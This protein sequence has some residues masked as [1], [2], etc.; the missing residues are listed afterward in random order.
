[1]DAVKNRLYDQL[2]VMP[3]ITPAS[4]S[5]I[6]YGGCNGHGGRT[7]SGYKE[8]HDD[9]GYDTPVPDIEG[10]RILKYALA[11]DLLLCNMCLKK[12][13][14]HLITACVI[15]KGHVTNVMVI[16]VKEAALQPSAGKRHV[17]WYAV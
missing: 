16:S 12:R 11:Y 3:V 14:S 10:E 2:R 15:L 6:P 13:N 1:M 17:D 5:L 8:V 7:G 4:S 9:Y